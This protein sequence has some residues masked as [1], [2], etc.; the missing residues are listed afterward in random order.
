MLR[1]RILTAAIAIPLLIWL[2]LWAPGWIY[3]PVVL[4]FTFLS[5]REMAAMQRVEIVGATWL[6]TGA[7]M[8]IALAMLVDA[9]GATLSAGIVV[10]LIGVLLGTLATA[11][12]MQR[13]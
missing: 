10:A 5:L 12:D 13:S 9:S 6:T 7:G 4:M 2:I 8:A 11:E 3:S 1:Q